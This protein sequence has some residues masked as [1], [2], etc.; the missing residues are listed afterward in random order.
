V[1]FKDLPDFFIFAEMKRDKPTRTRISK[2]VT[3]LMGCR[4]KFGMTG[5]FL[6]FRTP[7]ETTPIK[8]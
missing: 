8:G 3:F 5:G 1:G 4:N 6:I 2:A 7:V